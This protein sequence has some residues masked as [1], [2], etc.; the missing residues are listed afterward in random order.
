MIKKKL[1]SEEWLLRQVES[2]TRRQPSGDKTPDCVDDAFLK[3]Y[4]E[5]PAGV[6]LSD[7]RVDHVTSCNYCLGRLLQFRATRPAGV[8]LSFRYAAVAA[9]G[10]ACLL[11]GFVAANVWSRKHPVVQVQSA[12]LHRILDLSQYGTYRGDQSPSNPPLHLPAALLRLE[13]VLP[14][15]SQPGTYYI[16]VA[17]GKN[18]LNPVAAAKGTAVGSDA[19]TVVAV[20]LDLRGA[21]PGKYLLSTQLEGEDAP[22]TYPLQIE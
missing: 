13:I 10:L 15:L 21:T 19:R 2:Y 16:M 5:R 3:S 7:R 9:L 12:E 22:Y 6:S 4:A 11:I 17:A 1:N 14:R 20:S 8:S 18:G